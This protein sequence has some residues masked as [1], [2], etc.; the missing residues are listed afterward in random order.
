M[1]DYIHVR[2]LRNVVIL[3][4]MQVGSAVERAL[5]DADV[6]FRRRT[7]KSDALCARGAGVV[8]VAEHAVGLFVGWQPPKIRMVLK[9]QGLRGTIRSVRICI[10]RCSLRK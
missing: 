8:V 2:D 7:Q 10:D 9:P 3:S 1:S 4:C 6:D 5:A